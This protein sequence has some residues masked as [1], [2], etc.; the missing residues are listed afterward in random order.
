MFDISQGK[1]NSNLIALL[2]NYLASNFPSDYAVWQPQLFVAMES[3]SIYIFLNEETA[4]EKFQSTMA[5]LSNVYNTLDAQQK[6]KFDEIVGP[7]YNKYL[8]LYNMSIHHSSINMGEWKDTVAELIKTSESFFDVA[9]YIAN[10]ETSSEDKTNALVLLIGLYKKAEGLYGKLQNSG[11][12]DVITALST[13]IYSVDNTAASLD[14]AFFAVRSAYMNYMLSV[15]MSGTDSTGA[16]TA[17]MLWELYDG[18]GLDDFMAKAAEILVSRFENTSLSLDTVLAAMEAFANLTPESKYVFHVI[19][20]NYYYDS[21]NTFF[22]NAIANELTK[23]Y[24][25]Q[26]IPADSANALASLATEILNAE[27]AYTALVCDPENSEKLEA[28]IEKMEAVIEL[29][30]SISE[31]DAPVRDSV[32]GALYSYYFS[33]YT[34]VTAK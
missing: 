32:L 3:Y 6:S 25:D 34:A 28:F 16:P 30:N 29:Y 4:L 20:A 21:L 19:G 24:G 12:P 14:T 23:V 9:N 10:S 27:T 1:A 31:K 22:H 5:M 8:A 11:N 18:S 17:I 13:N 7:L 15:T 2:V 33:V 26:Q